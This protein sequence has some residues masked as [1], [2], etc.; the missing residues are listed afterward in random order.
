M[1]KAIHCTSNKE[2]FY[3]RNSPPS[4]DKGPPTA[5]HNS[6]Q[7]LQWNPASQTPLNSGHHDIAD[8]TESPDHFSIDFNTLEHPEQ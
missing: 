8:N 5:T 4:A 3:K 1:N 2:A 6:C 7:V